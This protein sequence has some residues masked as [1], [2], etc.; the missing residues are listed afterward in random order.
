MVRMLL[1]SVFVPISP[2]LE[3][4]VSVGT[5]LRM[6]FF[7]QSA[8]TVGHERAGLHALVDFR[9]AVVGVVGCFVLILLSCRV[10]TL[11]CLGSVAAGVRFVI[12]GRH[13]G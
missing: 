2:L 11:D 6:R 13:G 10:V 4:R 5:V 3:P 9:F 1:A 8:Q 12:V 7:Q